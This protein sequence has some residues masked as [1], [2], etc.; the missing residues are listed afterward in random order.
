M[1]QPVPVLSHGQLFVAD[2]TRVHTAVDLTPLEPVQH[3]DLGCWRCGPDA[4][5]DR[6]LEIDCGWYLAHEKRAEVFCELLVLPQNGPTLWTR[7]Y[8]FL[9]PGMLNR[10]LRHVLNGL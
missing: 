4:L 3:E 1:V 2:E 10:C 5:L 6:I 9:L 8:G 7:W